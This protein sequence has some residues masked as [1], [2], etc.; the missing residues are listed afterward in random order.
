[1]LSARS[2]SGMKKMKF[3][4]PDATEGWSMA[5]EVDFRKSRRLA[6]SEEKLEAELQVAGRAG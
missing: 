6:I 2:V 1:M 4:F 5:A 3:G